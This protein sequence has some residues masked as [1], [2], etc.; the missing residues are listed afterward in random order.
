MVML[1]MGVSEAAGGAVKAVSSG[2]VGQVLEL[3]VFASE[4][5]IR[6]SISLHSQQHVL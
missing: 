4:S 5:S 3:E 2:V 6:L 1:E